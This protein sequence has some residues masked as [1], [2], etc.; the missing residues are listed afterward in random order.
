MSLHSPVLHYTY[1]YV[2]TQVCLPLHTFICPYTGLFPLFVAK[3]LAVNRLLF[4]S[5]IFPRLCNFVVVDEVAVLICSPCT[6]TWSL[7]D[8][9]GRLNG[10][11]KQGKA[12]SSSSCNGTLG[13]VKWCTPQSSIQAVP[14]SMPLTRRQFS[15]YRRKCNLVCASRKSVT[16]ATPIFT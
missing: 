6:C 10:S 7:T 8:V 15:W 9:V 2:F 16:F 14:C 3:P 13:I 4:F 5:W 11:E 1:S 12:V